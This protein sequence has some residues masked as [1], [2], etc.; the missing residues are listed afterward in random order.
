[1]TTIDPTRLTSILR[2]LSVKEVGNKSNVA[3][4][5]GQLHE[6]SPS[7]VIEKGKPRDKDQLRKNLRDRL[8]RLKKQG[9]DFEKKAPGAVIREILL[10]EFGENIISH[11]E[12]NHIANNISSQIQTSKSLKDYLVVLVKELTDGESK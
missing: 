8:T 3:D 6:A 10:W 1:M 12:F 11:P 4:N 9:A 2:S 5:N 7:L